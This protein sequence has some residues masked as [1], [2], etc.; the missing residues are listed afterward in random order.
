M[1]PLLEVPSPPLRDCFRTLARSSQPVHHRGQW[2]HVQGP[3]PCE[4]KHHVTTCQAGSPT[5]SSRRPGPEQDMGQ[6][7]TNEVTV[8]MGSWGGPGPGFGHCQPTRIIVQPLDPASAP[9]G[10]PISFSVCLLSSLPRNL[11]SLRAPSQQVPGIR[12]P[13]CRPRHPIPAIGESQVTL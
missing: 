11:V 8:N 3:E 12:L 1:G 13:S 7:V 5:W 10:H 9:G 2:G 4:C 6:T